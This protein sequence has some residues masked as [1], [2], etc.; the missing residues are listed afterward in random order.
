MVGGATP[1]SCA[2]GQFPPRVFVF[3]IPVSAEPRGVSAGPGV[4][5]PHPG[6]RRTQAVGQRGLSRVTCRS[7]VAQLRGPLDPGWRDGDARPV[8]RCKSLVA[9]ATVQVPRRRGDRATPWSCAPGQF[10]PRVFVFRIPVSAEPRGVS[11]GPGVRWPHPGVRWTQGFRKRHLE[12]DVRPSSASSATSGGA[13]RARGRRH[14]R[15]YGRGYRGRSARGAPPRA[16]PRAGGG[17]G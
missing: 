15:G 1:W 17:A 14:G 2:P 6:V 3:R 10:P 4:R 12:G 8:R 5:W 11:A 7:A 16:R 9:I 13:S